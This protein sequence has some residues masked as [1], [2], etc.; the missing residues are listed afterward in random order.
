D[1]PGAV[2]TTING[3]PNPQGTSVGTETDAAGLVHGFTLSRNGTFNVFDPP[4]SVATTP[5][6]ISP[7]GTIVGGYVDAGGVSHGFILDGGNYT[8]FYAPGAAGTQL[9][10]INPSG[11]IVGFSCVNANCGARP[12]QSFSISKHGQYTAFDPPGATSDTASTINPAGEI[13]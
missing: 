13:V 9:T 4:G 3:G 11:T 10:G 6:F 1:F 7:Q 12:F 5:N 2:A 8:F